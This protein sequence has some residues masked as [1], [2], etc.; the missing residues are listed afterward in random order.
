[1]TMN[2]DMTAVPSSDVN[3]Y[4]GKA[5]TNAPGVQGPEDIHMEVTVNGE[6]Q[7]VGFREGARRIA[8]ELG[9]QGTAQNLD[10]GY[11]QLHLEGDK[12]AIREMVNRLHK[13]YL[14]SYAKYHELPK[15]ESFTNFI[16]LPSDP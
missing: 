11:V 13:Q 3:K 15:W 10:K 16:V 9:I 2:D 12:T 6:V 14:I 8:I 5:K 7:G 1:M 4:Q